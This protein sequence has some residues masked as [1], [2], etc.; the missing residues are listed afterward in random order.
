MDFDALTGK[1]NLEF[2]S[3]SIS[4]DFMIVKNLLRIGSLYVLPACLFPADVSAQSQSKPNIIFLMTD[5]QRWDA[6][7]INNPHIK[8]PNLDRLAR[9]GILFNQATCQAPMCVPSRNSMMFG[10]YPSQLGIRSNGSHSIGDQFLPCDPLP[11]RLKKAGYQT[12]GFGKTHWG[13]TDQPI[14]TRGFEF[15]VVGAK[16]VGLEKGALYQDDENPAG[17]AAY[18]REVANYGPGEEG[19]E[20]YLGKTSE[21]AD[22]DHRDGWVAEKCLEF[23]DTGLDPDRPLFLYLSFLKPHAGLNVPKRF[24]D[25]YNIND[26]PDTEQPPWAEE[27]DTHLAYSDKNNKFQNDRHNEWR[28]TW[29]KMTPFERRRTTLYYYANC[30]WL[31][32]YFGQ[33]LAKLEKAGRLKNALVVYTADHGDMLGERNYRFTKYCLYESSV[34]VPIMLSGTVVPDNLRGTIDNRP[35]ELVDL[36]PTIAKAAGTKH[37]LASPGLDLFSDQRRKGSF[38]EYHDSGAPAW[39]WRTNK[40]K[41]ILYSNL[42]SDASKSSEATFKGELYDLVNDPHE[43]KNL[44]NSEKHQKIREQLK[45]ELLEHLAGSFAGFPIGRG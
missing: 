19:V 17:L 32:D 43:W 23:L 24:V 31:D 7:G 41:L 29:L 3:L 33:A 45:T 10:L 37:Q 13:R 42:P 6:I 38:C 15:R 22:R 8:T 34:R 1:K 21:V 40:W 44:Y 35:A 14:D 9:N 4:Q 26:I 20:G 12:A 2:Q 11:E 36:Y 39:M 28:K 18:R 5:Q 16:E 25:L 30:T 27:Q